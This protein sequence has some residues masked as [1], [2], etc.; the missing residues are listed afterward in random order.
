MSELKDC[1]FCGGQALKTGAVTER[2]ELWAIH[3]ADCGV[4]ITEDTEEEVEC[5][6]NNR[7]YE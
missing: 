6:W 5:G 7:V 1:P 2:Y 3:C 4:R